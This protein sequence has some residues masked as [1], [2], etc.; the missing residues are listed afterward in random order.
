M[1]ITTHLVIA[2][3]FVSKCITWKITAGVTVLYNIAQSMTN[4]SPAF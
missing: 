4:T 2:L 1:Y 3:K